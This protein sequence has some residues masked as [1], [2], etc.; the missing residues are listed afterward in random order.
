M[1]TT[2]YAI[3][4]IV[5]DV[6][7]DKKTDAKVLIDFIEKVETEAGEW[8]SD[9][10]TVFGYVIDPDNGDDWTRVLDSDS[11]VKVVEGE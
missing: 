8:I 9:L 7:V 6:I 3:D 11:Q 4:L 10:I 2:K 5:G 1:I